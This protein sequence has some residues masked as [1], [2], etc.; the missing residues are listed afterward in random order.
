MK[1]QISLFS[2]E[3]K[4]STLQVTLTV[5]NALCLILSNILVV[6]PIN[7][8]GIPFLANTCAIIVFPITYILSD[9]FSEVYGYEWSRVTATYAFAGT[10]IASV[11]FGVMIMMRGN[12]DWASQEAL[13]QILGNTPQIVLASVFAFWFGDLIND[14]VFKFLKERDSKGNKFALRAIASSIAGKLVD[15]IIFTFVGL[16]F[17]SFEQ[18]VY[19]AFTDPWVQIGLETILLPLTALVVKKVRKAEDGETA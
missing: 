16:S 10:T 7:L 13:V 18:K 12:G 19:S 15:D 17:M 11:L 5:L 9:V 8:F 6:K 14:K 3:K 2:T 4:V 1:T